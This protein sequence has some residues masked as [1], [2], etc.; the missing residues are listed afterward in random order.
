MSQSGYTPILIYGSSTA[1]NVPLAANLTTSASGVELAINAADGK[2][3]YKDSGGVVQVL[4]TKAGAFGTVT[5][6]AATVPSF[7]SISGSPITSSGT[8]AIGL[9]GTALPTT[10]GGTGLTSFTANG[11]VYASSTSALATGGA[12]TFDGTGRLNIGTSTAP[13]SAVITNLLGKAGDNY[14][15]FAYNSGSGGGGL[16]GSATGPG[17][18]FFS[19]TGAIGS[20]TYSEQ[21]RLTSTGLG[22]GTSSPTQKLSVTGNGGFSGYVNT[23]GGGNGLRVDG[24]LMADRD[25]NNNITLIGGSDTVLRVRTNSATVA[26]FDSSGNLGLGVTP[27]AWGTGSGGYKAINIGTYGAA[28]DYE[29]SG[30]V[31]L[32]SNCYATASNWIYTQSLGA[33]RFESIL[34]Q[35]R[36]YTA[37]SGTAGNAISFTQAMTLDASGNLVVGGTSAVYTNANRGNITINGTS[38]AL[39]ALST[40]GTGRAY[41]YTDGSR[42]DLL[43]TQNDAL[44]FGTN[45]TE[46]ARIDSSGNLLVGT[47]STTANGNFTNA[48]TSAVVS[49]N[50]NAK[51]WSI[52]NNIAASNNATVDALLLRD[53]TGTVVGTNGLAGHFYVFV[54]DSSG[55]NSFSGIYA[56]TGTGNGNS[57]V[58]IVT[59]TT[60]TRGTSPVLSVQTAAD[61]GGALKLTIT[62]INNATYTNG[63]SCV[64]FVGVLN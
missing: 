29:T 6:V 3:F 14:T 33:S 51:Q 36:W 44:T 41:L 48:K 21:M 49:T 19:Y 43:N 50:S 30:A 2:L 47:T 15:Q 40:G 17:L 9:S 28:Y 7:L 63:S 60:V 54:R 62:Y 64:S 37:P 12:L 26:T 35:H 23:A 34:G 10:S 13:S 52:T 11:V 31:G 39:L 32:A 1:S 25:Q 55:A 8:L 45:N 20:E 18:S 57:N 46:R 4:A 59:V 58:S 56:V 16:V 53:A 42:L 5:S 22:I 38:T 27:S 61:T 24:V